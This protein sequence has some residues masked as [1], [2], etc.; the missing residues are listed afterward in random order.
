M[1][2]STLNFY[3]CR[4]FLFYVIAIFFLFF[5]FILLVDVIELSRQLS[6]IEDV[7]FSSIFLVALFRAPAFAENVVPFAVLF[8]ASS[9]L[10]VLNKRLELVVARASGVSAWQFLFPLAATAFV[11]GLLSAL[12]YNPLALKGDTLSKFAKSQIFTKTKGNL[13]N[14]D[15]NFWIRLSEQDGD[16][17]LGARV[18]ENKGTKLTAVT[19]YRFE[20]DGSIRERIDAKRADFMVKDGESYYVL[21][22][23]SV[24]VPGE[25]VRSLD[26]IDLK[27]RITKEELEID[28]TDVSTESIWALPERLQRA[29]HSGKSELPY[30]SRIYSLLGTPLLFVAMVLLAGTISLTFARFGQNRRLILGG[31]VAGFVLYVATKLVVTFGS[32]GLVPPFIATWSPALIATLICVTVLLHQ[33]DG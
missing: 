8:G 32:N 19:A 25:K 2:G 11:L 26:T 9:A 28:Q 15:E 27:V 20:E 24:S 10:L 4:K 14:S 21:K 18:S 6:N 1:I 30:Y 23:A 31:I 33:E 5:C 29:R 3:L 16:V 17:V 22:T 7:K 13:A 12:V